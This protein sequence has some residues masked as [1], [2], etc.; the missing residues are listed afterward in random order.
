MI[1]FCPD[2]QEQ[3][4]GLLGGQVGKGAGEQAAHPLGIDP[5]LDSVDPRSGV[6]R[7]LGDR[8][9]LADLAP[10]VVTGQVGGDPEEP[11][12]G[13][14][15]S[16][17]EVGAAIEGHQKGLR[18]ELVGQLAVEAAAQVAMDRLEVA[19]EDDAED[20]R[21]RERGGDCLG[22]DRVLAHI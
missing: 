12:A 14:G 4:V 11:G 20:R 19:F 8:P 15:A 10:A 5:G 6:R 21:V 2:E 22:V 13:P 9:Q 1:E 16:I 17:V 7:Q 3:H 18:G